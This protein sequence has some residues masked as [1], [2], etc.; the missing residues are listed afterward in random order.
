MPPIRWKP[1]TVVGLV[2]ETLRARTLVPD[3]EEWPAG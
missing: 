2:Q 3:V 1:V